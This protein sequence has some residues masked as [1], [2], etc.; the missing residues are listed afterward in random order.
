MQTIET[1]FRDLSGGL[2]L[3]VTGADRIRFLNGQT[4]NDVRKAV[5]ECAQEACVLNARGQMEAHLFLFAT[6]DSIWITADSKLRHALP[7]RLARYII[8][9]DVVIEDV[10]EKF[11]LLHVFSKVPP[12][13]TPWEFCLGARRLNSRGWDIWLDAGQ[14]GQE[15][16]PYRNSYCEIT[17]PEWERIRIEAGIPSWGYEL[18][19]GILPPEANLDTRAIDYEKG[20]YIGQE[21]ISRMKMSGQLRQRLCGVISANAELAPD[22]DLLASG[23]VVG[24]ITSTV[25]SAPLRAW[26]ALAMIKRGFN[27]PGTQLIARNGSGESS[28]Q[29][30]SLPFVEHG[31]AVALSNS[32]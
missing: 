6:P 7:E 22:S 17:G 12:Q 14:K 1:S 29:T 25:F 2:R 4:T 21:V 18:R 9:D 26:I 31:G 19:P 30:V 27:E 32:Q 3:R 20:C 23:K 10:S 28:V 5:A 13:L 11:D 16:T 24:Q 8:A 15:R